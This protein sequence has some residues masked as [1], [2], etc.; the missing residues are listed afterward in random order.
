[1]LRKRRE[2]FETE[3]QALEREYP[4]F[5]Q[6]FRRKLDRFEI[7][8][9]KRE[10]VRSELT[11]TLTLIREWYLRAGQLTGLGEDIFFLAYQEVLDL[12]SGDEKSTDYIPLR[13]QVYE[14]YSALPTYPPV[15]RGRF[16]PVQWAADPNRRTDFY[17][18]TAKIQ[19]IEHPSMIKGYPGSAGQVEG[20]VH[21]IDNPDEGHLLQPGEILL[22]V[23]TNVGWT[24]IF[25]KA[26]AV[27]TDIGAPLAHAAIVA[28]ELGIPAVV[29]CSDATMRLKTGDRVRV[30][31]GQG[32]VEI[33]T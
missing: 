30:D 18:P 3:W 26:A 8:V 2:E 5:A 27:I 9:Q 6:K 24:P 31:G 29:G 32:I 20:V 14:R 28:R 22:A 25:P 12:L 21:H 15:I 33:L 11:R 7:V 4:K 23:T 13:R 16:D 1:L 19:K 10:D 17:D